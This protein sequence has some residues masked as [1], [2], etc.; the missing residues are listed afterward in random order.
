[1]TRDEA[2]VGANTRAFRRPDEGEMGGTSQSVGGSDVAGRMLQCVCGAF[3]SS[4]VLGKM[5]EDMRTEGAKGVKET[6][7]GAKVSEH[8]SP[9]VHP[10]C[11]FRRG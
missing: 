5:V 8:T 11:P 7:E 2:F 3:P 1:M 10:M 9:S 6:E 4:V